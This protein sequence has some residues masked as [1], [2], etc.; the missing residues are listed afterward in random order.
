MNFAKIEILFGNDNNA[1]PFIFP[2]KNYPQIIAPILKNNIPSPL[3][4]K[5]LSN[6]PTKNS[7]LKNYIHPKYDKFDDV[8]KFSESWVYPKLPTEY[9]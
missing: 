3:N 4:F 6:S 5:F 7:P 2:F 9:P 1:F 8:F